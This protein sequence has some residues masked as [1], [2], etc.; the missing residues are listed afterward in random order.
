METPSGFKSEVRNSK[1]EASGGR[2][3]RK[4]PRSGPEI[5]D[6][7]FELSHCFLPGT[8]LL[9]TARVIDRNANSP[10]IP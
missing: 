5:L 1:S 6:A 7:D 2:G 8:V 9:S 3:A 10:N 4:F